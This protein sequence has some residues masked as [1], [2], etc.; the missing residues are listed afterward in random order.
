MYTHQLKLQQISREYFA[1]LQSYWGDS[2]NVKFDW[3]CARITMPLT[4]SSY[5]PLIEDF[6]GHPNAYEI[7]TY[8]NGLWRNLSGRELTKANLTDLIDAL[9]SDKSKSNKIVTCLRRGSHNRG[10]SKTRLKFMELNGIITSFE[11]ISS[12]RFAADFTLEGI[13]EG[14]NFIGLLDQKL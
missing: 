9:S 7:S 3:L 13:S 1:Q 8:Q 12:S 11:I 6:L 10:H 2:R 4:Y 14:S 5:G